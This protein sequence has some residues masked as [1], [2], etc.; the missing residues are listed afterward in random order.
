MA[1]RCLR[2]GWFLHSFALSTVLG[3]GGSDGNGGPTDPDPTPTIGITLSPTSL[4]LDQGT[5]AAEQ[6]APTTGTVTVNLTRGGGY[7]GAVTA[8]LQGAPTG[9]SASPVTI[10]SGSTS[11]TMT[12]E[13]TEAA[14][15]GT[16]NMT[17]QATGSGVS[18]ASASLSLT[19]N[20]LPQPGFS[21]AVNPASVSL[22]Q[23]NSTTNVEV[24][25]VNGFTGNVDLAASG[26]PSGL[27][28][29][30]N[31][32]SVL[33]DA[34]QVQVAA[35]GSVTPG[36]YA[37]TIT[38]SATGL[39][40]ATTTLSVEVT[41]SSG[42]GEQVT[43]TYC[44]ASG[45]PSWVA[46]QDGTGPWVPIQPVSAVSRAPGRAAA[47]TYQFAISSD[48]AGLTTVFESNGSAQINVFY[49]TKNELGFQGDVHCPGTGITKSATGTVA[50]LG[51]LDQATISI[52]GPFA[53]VTGAGP[54]DF[55]VTGI[56]DGPVDLIASQTETTFGGG[57]VLTETKKLILLRNQ[58]NPD[59]FDYG[60]LD[61]NSGQAFAPDEFTVTLN[62]MGADGAVVSS[63]F[64]TAN[65]GTN[66]FFTDIQPLTT[67]IR[68]FP[69]IPASELVQG[70][71]QTVGAFALD[72]NAP[73]A[74]KARQATIVFTTPGDQ[75]L[76][77]GPDLNMPTITVPSVTPYVVLR[78]QLTTQPE[79]DK[80]IY[81]TFGQSGGR[82]NSLAIGATGA[83]LNGMDFDVTM[84]DY[85]GKAGFNDLW[86]LEAGI[87]TFYV[88][89]G[90]GWTGAGG[91]TGNPFAD[92]VLSHTAQRNGT[93][94]P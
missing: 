81:A 56:P 23:G 74:D 4:T 51:P 89:F 46:V 45:V 41:Q 30:F 57:S 14:Q 85:S 63:N 49:A 3:C 5:A 17:V 83:Y 8:T 35:A 21:I 13:V 50:G 1:S 60:T 71:F 58:N 24:T 87:E 34:S 73:F 79:Y 47:A 94:T 52:G 6:A 80:Y 43:L 93:I 70:D 37:V 66:A 77:F 68:T 28:I 86:G 55:T 36:T 33:G 25:R 39:D 78:T 7:T 15:P 61:F 90:A 82:G 9:V 69:T 27:T 19:V 72:P 76:T 92:G 26:Q 53:I 48:K 88:V 18:A 32:T 59:G 29:S 62:N 44:D 12:I 16:T 65:G 2:P 22:Q 20:E 40:D 38:G 11:G 54:F 31:P 64:V 75:T 10:A 84:P 67:N 42:G 91:V